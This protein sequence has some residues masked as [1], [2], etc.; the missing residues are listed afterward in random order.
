MQLWQGTRRE[1]TWF[2]PIHSVPIIIIIIIIIEMIKITK[3]M[4][5]ERSI[6]ADVGNKSVELV[7]GFV[8]VE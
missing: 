4:R 6:A 3:D 5:R 8:A 1:T 2:F 7:H